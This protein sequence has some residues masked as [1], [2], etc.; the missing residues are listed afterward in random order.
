MKVLKYI[1]IIVTISTLFFR[2]GKEEPRYTVPSAPVSF[3]IN[4]SS[5]DNHLEGGGH[6]AVYLKNNKDKADYD[7]L[8][9]GVKSV[10]SFVGVRAGLPSYLGFS[11]L[12]IINTASSLSDHPFAVFDL[13]CPREDLINVRIIPTDEGTAVCPKC[14]AVFDLLSGTGRCTNGISSENLQSYH[15]RKENQ[16]EFRV[17]YP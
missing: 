8:I 5:L 12:L 9:T 11:G 17:Y 14:G 6:I 7:E 10:R 3:T 2:C 16:N 4:L 15:I 13:C 1:L